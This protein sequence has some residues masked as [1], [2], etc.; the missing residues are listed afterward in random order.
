[1]KAIDYRRHFAILSAVSVAIIFS[2]YLPIPEPNGFL[3]PIFIFGLIGALH[4][5]ALVTSLRHHESIFKRISVVF[6]AAGL[7]IL[8]P[9]IG[10]VVTHLLSAL[11]GYAIAIGLILASA[12]GIA[13][14]WLVIR[15]TLIRALPY[16]Y[17][18]FTV[19]L[20]SITTLLALACSA[21][22]KEF[23]SIN[24]SIR[25]DISFGIPFIAWWFAFSYSL[26]RAET[27]FLSKLALSRPAAA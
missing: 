11:D 18:L 25:G 12:L 3:K 9:L 27:I 20:C 17:L 13:S 8:S 7:S 26:Y 21:W 1:M 22:L 24:Y 10:L 15:M 2:T 4:A 23:G 5:I 14:Y 16:K 6:I 19:I